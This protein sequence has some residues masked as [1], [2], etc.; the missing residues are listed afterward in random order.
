MIPDLRVNRVFRGLPERLAPPE[1]LAQPDRPENPV[2]SARLVIPDLL[3]IREPPERLVPR[4]P[5]EPSA[6]LAT[7]EILVPRA[8]SVRL[9]TLVLPDL[10][11]PS[12]LR[13]IPRRR[14]ASVL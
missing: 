3:A 4:V 2:K 11:E 12:V 7:K 6:L 10:P 8:K 5:P 13:A 14:S 1:R 9:A